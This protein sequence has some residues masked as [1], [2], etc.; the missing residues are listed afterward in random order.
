[1]G[2]ALSFLGHLGFSRPLV[3]RFAEVPRAD[4]DRI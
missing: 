2:P 1:L 4:G 3:R